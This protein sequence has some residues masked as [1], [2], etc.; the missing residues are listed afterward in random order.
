MKGTKKLKSLFID[1]KVP[2]EIRSSIPILTTSDND[3]IWVYG[4]RIADIY[5][6]TSDTNK[7]LF[8]KGLS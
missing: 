7:V 6:V 4:M 1:E 2:Q 3:I 5:R 8:I